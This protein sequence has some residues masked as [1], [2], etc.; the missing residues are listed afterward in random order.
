MGEKTIINFDQY[1][2]RE[3]T[4]CEKYDARVEK[5]GKSN[6]L[7]LWVADMDFATSPAIIDA[8]T[9][10][11]SHPIFGYH[12][13]HDNYLKSIKHWMFKQ[14][15][16]R[17]N[18]EDIHP[19]NS[20]VSALHIAVESLSSHEDAILIQTPIYPPFIDAVKVHQRKLLE[21]QLLLVD[22]HYEIDFEDFEKK[23]QKA[24]LFLFC[25]PHNPTGRLWCREELE[26][27]VAI[28]HK[29][30]LIIISDEVHAD[31]VYHDRHIPIAT[32]ANAKLRTITLNA[33]SKSFNVASIVNAYAIIHN[34]LLKE[35]FLKLFKQLSL[36]HANPLSIAVT[37]AAYHDSDDW[38]ESLKIYL[39]N[40]LRFINEKKDKIYPIKPLKVEGT[41]LQWL[42]CREMGLDNA[43]LSS[44]FINEAELGLNPGW[45]FGAGG[46]GFMRLNVAHPMKRIMIA[47]EQIEKALQRRK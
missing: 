42:D 40:T 24:K 11:I 16:W 36:L 30:D 3:G 5:F 31:I 10:R 15:A 26:K 8:L 9:K 12:Y 28:C 32:F 17:I 20:I 22:G 37:I 44:W 21:N 18:I 23:A 33:P 27:M 38:L 19:I 39:S 29:Y 6:L 47:I 34:P 45:T 46:E 25:S 43:K 1:L 35:K 13:Y 41:Y 7:P 14:H 2:E 4:F